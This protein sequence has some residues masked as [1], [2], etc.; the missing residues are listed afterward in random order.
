MQS[1]L[2]QSLQTI[3]LIV[4]DD[5][6]Q[7]NTREKLGAIR[8][9]RMRVYYQANAGA[10]VAINRGLRMARGQYLAILNSD[11]LYTQDRLEKAVAEL[12]R[13][14]DIDFVSSWI[15]LIDSTG[16]PIGVKQGWENMLPWHAEIPTP[17]IVQDNDFYFN[18]FISNFIST[19][20]N[21]V[22]RRQLFTDVGEFRN[23]RFAH[24]WDFF[25]RAMVNKKALVISQPLVKY[26]LHGDNTIKKDNAGMMFE[27]FWV[28]IANICNLSLIHI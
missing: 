2:Q 3:E 16:Q 20:S 8:D 10:H 4:I 26:R 15:E 23:L 6:S 24:D 22:M 25:L 18:L 12:E 27:I 19:T 5:G 7:D 17:S 21:I 9:S 28:L 14:I 1:V 11:D 13:N